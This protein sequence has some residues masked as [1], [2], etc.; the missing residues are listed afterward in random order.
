MYIYSLNMEKYYYVNKLDYKNNNFNKKKIL[1]IQKFL[2]EVKNDYDNKNA[3]ILDDQN[4]KC[5]YNNGYFELKYK[6]LM[7]KWH[8]KWQNYFGVKYA[9]KTIKNHRTDIL[10]NDVCI[11]F[12]HSP[13]NIVEVN[14]RTKCYEN[15]QKK[16]IWVLDFC[17]K[18]GKKKLYVSEDNVV[19]ISSKYYKNFISQFKD[20]KYC[21]V[22][23]NKKIL[24]L[25]MSKLDRTNSIYEFKVSGYIDRKK[26]VKL[27][28]KSKLNLSSSENF[29]DVL[30]AEYLGKIYINQR[31]AGSGKTWESIQLINLGDAFLEEHDNYERYICK[32]NFIYLTKLHSARQNI[33]KEFK[34]QLDDNQLEN[35]ENVSID[36]NNKSDKY[37]II[38]CRNKRYNK[39]MKVIIATFDSFLWNVGTKDTDKLTLDV[40]KNIVEDTKKPKKSFKSIDIN[41]SLII[42]D[43]AQDLEITYSK[44]LNTIVSFIKCDF[45]LIGDQ[46]QSIWFESNIYNYCKKLYDECIDKDSFYIQYDVGTNNC[47]RF[48]NKA[49]M[50]FVNDIIPFQKFGLNK[51]N[52]IGKKDDAIINV[53]PQYIT[54]NNYYETITKNEDNINV[55]INIKKLNDDVHKIICS[56]EN[57]SLKTLILPNEFLI[58]SPVVSK[59]QTGLFL[60]NLCIALEDFWIKL[61]NNDAYKKTVLQNYK[62][63]IHIG[64]KY[65]YKVIKNNEHMNYC[66]L[67]KAE[68]NRPIDLNESKYKTR[69]LSIHASKGLTSKYVFLVGLNNDILLR[70]TNNDKN[71]IYYSLIH[72]ALTRQTNLL[73]L[74][75]SEKCNFFEDLKR[76]NTKLSESK[77]TKWNN[78]NECIDDL[79][80]DKNFCDK[81]YSKLSNDNRYNDNRK[82]VR[83][84]NSM[85]SINNID[86]NDHIM[87]Y[88]VLCYKI[89]INFLCLYGF[90]QNINNKQLY[91]KH[92]MLNITT[93]I[94]NVRN[95][96]KY[97]NEINK[98]NK[99]WRKRKN[100]YGDNMGLNDLK[101]PILKQ[102]NEYEKCSEHVEKIFNNVK[103]KIFE[104]NGKLDKISLSQINC[105]IELVVTLYFLTYLD[106]PYNS[107]NIISDLYKIIYYWSNNFL[108]NVD[109]KKYDCLCFKL[110]KQQDDK[111]KYVKFYE[112]IDMI[113]NHFKNLDIQLQDKVIKYQSCYVMNSIFLGM[114]S[115]Y[116]IDISSD[117]NHNIIIPKQ[118]L[119]ILNF[120]EIYINCLLINAF[121]N[122]RNKKDNNVT[123][124]IFTLDMDP[125]YI[126]FSKDCVD[127]VKSDINNWCIKRLKKYNN[128][129]INSVIKKSENQKVDIQYFH[130]GCE[131]YGVTG[132][133]HPLFYNNTVLQKMYCYLFSLKFDDDNKKYPEYLN[134]VIKTKFFVVNL[135]KAIEK[136][137]DVCNTYIEYLDEYVDKCFNLNVFECKEHIR[138]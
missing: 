71:L 70:W 105:P 77:L 116:F 37:N 63:N 67:H 66:Q 69:M 134:E 112:S 22:D 16:V 96:N 123:F 54:L 135:I 31:G 83:K 132:E 9:E 85:I 75:T 49:N 44:Y 103:R 25:R 93:K 11:E 111:N 92:C 8:Q 57:L 65:Y 133:N 130:E 58:I 6:A 42:I 72:V 79:L 39:N 125:M 90:K 34:K 110:F 108:N 3:Y 87:R 81:V 89:L 64:I 128:D 101:C 52:S 84:N 99:N 113:D 38:T 118:N 114:F 88:R 19:R 4:R 10:I 53:D 138:V 106:F 61:F 104:K 48:I 21:Y 14:D 47:R 13:I 59:G 30:T 109:H 12:Q 41:N 50:H 35:I 27:L 100:G 73:F 51:I 7:S 1:N 32:Q 82:L 36:D 29:N 20:L 40:F 86:Y 124:I 24:C 15:N 76:K 55:G 80:H 129:F 122:I 26:F 95:Y 62:K 107:E 74:G 97:T 33:M 98:Y 68:E 78:F 131:E 115:K 45:H 17:E 23:Y 2:E 119:N 43:E 137:G 28:L 91:A 5:I 18:F 136:S 121:L 102:V 56:F 60:N 126:K 120:D 117:T 127:Y 94:C 46:L